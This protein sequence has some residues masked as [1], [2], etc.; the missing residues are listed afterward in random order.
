MRLITTI[1]LLA[2]LS[3]TAQAAEPRSFSDHRAM[4][5]DAKLNVRNLSGL[6][7]VEGWEK[8]EFDLAAELGESAEKIDISGS[9]AD[10]KVEVKIRKGNHSYNNGDT[11]LKLR[12]PAGVALTLDGTSADLFVRGTKGAIV[13]R[14]VSGDV[15]LAIGSKTITVQ[16]VSGDV[17]LDTP[18]ARE[19]QLNTVSG[20]TDVKGAAGALSA[21]SVS[22][23]V[24]VEGGI[25]TQLDLKSVSGDIGVR[26]GFAA[27]AKVKAESLSGDV[28]VNAP[29]S[30]SG[31][32]SLKTFSGDKHCD[33]EGA[34]EAADSKRTVLKIGEGR[35]QFSLTSF[36]GDVTLD[37]Q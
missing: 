31:E 19:T 24:Q 7:E 17:R 23:D 22:G 2:G 13:A 29:A 11:H 4:N 35:G 21:E 33:F 37:K 15:D 16:T 5:A 34:R 14:S 9:A 3:L 32:V 8:N 36:S 18:A 6:I 25:F 26:A 12:V 30:F 10:L 27:D 20:D 1:A 28:H